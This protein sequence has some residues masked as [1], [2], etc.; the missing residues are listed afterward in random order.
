MITVGS[1]HSSKYPV[2]PSVANRSFVK[3]GVCLYVTPRIGQ[4]LLYIKQFPLKDQCSREDSLHCVCFI[5]VT[6]NERR[7]NVTERV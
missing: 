6:I 4:E 1:N 5:G 2:M 7:N 3:C